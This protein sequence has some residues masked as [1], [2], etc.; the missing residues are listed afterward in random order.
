MTAVWYSAHILAFGIA[1]ALV[2]LTSSSLTSALRI[3]A[4]SWRLLA[5]AILNCAQIVI[6][7]QV[8]SL[9]RSISI[10]YL[11]L[12]HLLVFAGLWVFGYRPQVIL[13]LGDIIA[14]WNAI[15]D[16]RNRP[17]QLLVICTCLTGLVTLVLVFMVA[18]NNYDSMTYHLARVGY[19]LQQRSLES[20]PS[21][22]IRQTVFPANAEILILWQVVLLRMD[23]TAGL[24]QWLGWCISILAVFKLSRRMGFS[25]VSSIF[26]AGVFASFPQAV[27][28]S[29]STQND[30]LTTC[31]VVSAFAFAGN[32]RAGEN[33]T[34]MLALS[35]AAMGLA[36]GTKATSFIAVPG[37]VLFAF[38]C[39]RADNAQFWRKSCA[40][41]LA[42]SLGFLVLGSYFY[43]QNLQH[44]RHPLGPPAFRDEHSLDRIEF[45]V[46]WSNF[47]RS[48]MQF[49]S[50]A[51]LIPPIPRI[52]DRIGSVYLTFAE[53]AFDILA[54]EKSLPNNDFWGANWSAVSGL[55]MH[56]DATAFGPLFG[57]MVIPLL[58]I[59]LLHPSLSRNSHLLRAMALTA[60]VFWVVI[61]STVRWHIWIARLFMPMAALASPLFAMI[62]IEKKHWWH[63][64]INTV[65]VVSCCVCLASSIYWN[66]MK[67]ISG[68]KSV[69]RLDRKEQMLLGQPWIEDWVRLLN[70]LPLKSSK[71]CFIPLHEDVYEYPLFG[72]HFEN[73]IIPL[74]VDGSKSQSPQSLPP[75]AN[76]VFFQG[77]SQEF[78][79]L[80]SAGSHKQRWL[81]TNDLRPF[82][83]A[84]RKPGSGWKAL[85]DYDRFGHLFARS[86][87]K[88][89]LGQ[90][91][92]LPDHLRG[93]WLQ[94]QDKWVGKHFEVLVRLDAARPI[95]KIKGGMSN[96]P[97][98]P[99]I[100][101][102]EPNRLLFQRLTVQKPGPFEWQ[103]SLD[104]L[105]R[106]Y[107]D[108]YILLT[109]S[110]SSSFNPQRLGMWADDRDLSWQLYELKLTPAS[111]LPPPAPPYKQISQWWSDKWVSNPL[112][113]DVK[114]DPGTPVVELVGE[115]PDRPAQQPR[116]K[117][118]FPNGEE[119]DLFI[120]QPGVFVRY[121]LLTS[122]LS[123]YSG[124]FAP[125]K[126]VSS[127]S[128]NPSHQ[129]VS[130]DDRDLSWRLLEIR[131]LSRAA[132]AQVQ[133][134]YYT[135]SPWWPDKWVSKEF[136]IAVLFDKARPYL[137]LSGDIPPQVSGQSLS[138]RF[139]SG[140]SSI[141]LDGHSGI[142]SST[143]PLDSI[144]SESDG[145]YIPLE[146]MAVRSF[147]PQKTGAS[148][149]TRSL[150]WQLNA[151]TLAARS[152]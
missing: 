106:L 112:A 124:R 92:E 61:V 43:I 58:L 104:R 146:I 141:I 2:V 136:K 117:A 138:V 28:Q 137:K 108:P 90:V 49:L 84:M 139:P 19:Y 127:I 30:L 55:T 96:A 79:L 64:V 85:L 62:Y 113:L 122:L 63:T 145:K 120:S 107:T 9:F 52:R 93:F 1:A 83:A 36:L 39:F 119:S 70:T 4:T 100:E 144:S 128:F 32:C 103:V 123:Q 22:N 126:F 102:Y 60:L 105:V 33:C 53:K 67:P 95:L 116:L 38:A 118:V 147:I 57:I 71:L 77:E 37:L 149:D 31:F 110:S 75:D 94:W 140:N 148:E 13:T 133:P 14:A 130:R 114:V 6:A 25:P 132:A 66:E 98:A 87:V 35:G 34:A 29:T 15:R 21:A 68:Q 101:V 150:A 50:P 5:I 65:L 88:E 76:Y 86:D 41:V 81:G 97:E 47:G 46:A 20:F 134:D 89:R 42:I 99:I 3:K 143:V 91:Q 73:A 23:V 27:L 74:R 8:L 54:I 11:L 69:F 16:L 109:F 78:H 129:G 115:S 151:L 125:I 45:K 59:S 18:P 56:E 10:Y 24:V 7:I 40:L 12:F 135:I 48:T 131:L 152:K 111:P 121:F 80:R 17:I 82:L 51:G 72:K 44:Y 142:F 26:A